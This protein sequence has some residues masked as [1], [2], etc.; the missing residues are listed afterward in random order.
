MPRVVVIAFE[1]AQTLDVAGPVEVFGQAA[2]L[3]KDAPYEVVVASPKG[4]LCRTTTL[5]LATTKLSQLTPRRSDIVLVA[6]GP[7]AAIRCAVADQTLR[8]WLVRAHRT[9]RITGSVCSGAFVL[10]AAGLLDGKRAVTHWLGCDELRARFPRIRVESDAIFVR[11]GATWTSA[12]VTTG[13]DMALAIVEDD[14]DAALADAIA[15]RLV[16]YARRPGHQS[17]WSE[18]LVAQTEGDAGLGRAVQWARANITRA[19]LDALARRA[20]LSPRTFHRRCLATLATTPKKL[21]ERLRV[22]HARMLL[23]GRPIAVKQLAQRSGFSSTAQLQHAFLRVLGVT[24][25]DYRLLH[26]HG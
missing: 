10:A 13:I 19:D 24:P 7:D 22:E 15:A 11:D 8:A 12:G 1:G 5:T 17:Q 21:L 25:R 14:H 16:L 3:R 26:G 9:A 6:G 23:Q 20:A 2:R 4:G 18:L